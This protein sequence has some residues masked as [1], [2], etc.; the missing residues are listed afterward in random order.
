[1]KSLPNILSVLRIVFSLSM[2]FAY[3]SPAIFISLYIL[4]GL[5]DIADGFLARKYNAE[6]NLGAKL[7]SVGDFVFWAVVLYILFD[8]T[9]SFRNQYIL[10]AVVITA[11]IRIGNIA[12]TRIKF[13]QWNIIHTIGNKLTG[14]LLFV[15]TPILIYRS[16]SPLVFIILVGAVAIISALEE[17][18]ILGVSK[19]YNPNAKSIFSN[20]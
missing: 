9:D 17:T 14:L 11:V 19:T 12:F 13:C 10:T 1:M 6:T 4:S 5:T 7:D 15:C 8:K 16:N 3:N 18:V 2:L 20:S